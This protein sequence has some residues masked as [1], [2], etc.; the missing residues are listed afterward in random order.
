MRH[1]MKPD[2]RCAAVNM[3]KAAPA[4]VAAA[5]ALIGTHAMSD[6]DKSPPPAGPKPFLS[7][8]H[9]RIVFVGDSITDGNTY[10]QLI[11]QALVAAG[12]AAPICINAGVGGD[13]AEGMSARLETTAIA[14]QPTLVSISAG[15]NDIL[16]GVPA[17][18]YEAH[19]RMMA[20]RL[21]ALN[22]PVLLL[23]P[24]IL[25]PQ[26]AQADTNLAQYVGAIH[27]VAGT[28]G[29]QVAQV[30]RLMKEARAA[31]RQILEN[32]SVHPNFEGQRLIARAVLDALG[33]VDVPVPEKIS[34]EMYPGVITNWMFR[35][36]PEKTVPLDPESVK[37]VRPDESWTAYVLP[38]TDPQE[39]P[40]LEI[41]RQT[42]FALSLDK[43]VPGPGSKN[44]QGCA[45]LK[46]KAPRKVFFN[47]GAELQTVWLNGERIFKFS[48]PPWPGFHAGGNR[49][50]AELIKGDNVVI[51]ETGPTF[52]LSVTE[53][54]DW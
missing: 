39:I 30:N 37:A 25:G 53:N 22:I 41:E 28:Y 18:N 2:N 20:D 27:R 45:I 6:T 44:F 15:I 1:G 19:I 48:A 12:Y 5:C 26:H 29:C 11:R 7:P 38:E 40:W 50:P 23:T 51:I 31:G 43:K 8:S 16:H 42:G 24:S 32:D 4:L 47:T 21:K 3:K 14:Y 10:P 49:V 13:T 46:E 35:R 9:R 54:H 52:F 34:V 36:L 33:Y 17:T